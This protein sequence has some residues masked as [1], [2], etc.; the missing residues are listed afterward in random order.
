MS[1]SIFNVWSSY[2]AF[3]SSDFFFFFFLLEKQYIWWQKLRKIHISDSRILKSRRFQLLNFVLYYKNGW[4]LQ[5]WPHMKSMNTIFQLSA[6]RYI[7]R[8]YV[9]QLQRRL[10]SL[11][12]I[13]KCNGIILWVKKSDILHTID[14]FISNYCKW[15]LCYMYSVIHFS[16][17]N[18]V[19]H[20]NKFLKYT[21]LFFVWTR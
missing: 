11:V 17:K 7:T 1:H 6:S 21:F 8:S 18:I 20:E 5:S 4:Y 16:L 13:A 3:L 9:D 12:W 2:F 10:S 19:N 15:I 14:D